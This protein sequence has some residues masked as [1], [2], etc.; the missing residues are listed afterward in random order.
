MK[1]MKRTLMM[2][3]AV[4]L[5]TGC[6]EDSKQD[7][8]VEQ[9]IPESPSDNSPVVHRAAPKDASVLRATFANGAGEGWNENDKVAVYS[10][11]SV[12]YNTYELTSGAGTASAVFTRNTGEENYEDGGAIFALTSIDRIYSFSATV[13]GD[14]KVSVTIPQQYDIAEVGA[15]EGGSRMPVPY[16]GAVN[17]GEDGKLETTF[18]GM[19]ALLKIDAAT[20]PEGTTAVVLTTKRDGYLGADELEPGQGEPLS[21]TFDTELKEGASVAPNRIFRSYDVLRVNLDTYGE[22]IE[23]YRYLFIPVIAGS[24][25]KLHVLAITD[26]I[27]EGYWE[28][29]VLKTFNANNPFYPNTI[30]AVEQQSTAIHTPR[31]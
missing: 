30:V 8:F 16:W 4:F 15:P 27:S 6:S 7:S 18:Q 9:P 17:F 2:G 5:L 21:G 19:T 25:A 29:K 24:Y 31:I 14:A 28:G 3:L 13:K 12:F 22:D 1:K 23:Q 11:K 10:L 26:E 20:L